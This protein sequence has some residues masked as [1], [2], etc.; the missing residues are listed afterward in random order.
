MA[1]CITDII[2]KQMDHVM[3]LQLT[4]SKKL[5]REKQ[6]AIKWAWL[7]GVSHVIFS[8]DR[9]RCHSNS[10]LQ[11]TPVNCWAEQTPLDASNDSVFLPQPS[12]GRGSIAL[13][14]NSTPI[15]QVTL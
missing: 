15:M 1:S 14:S 8:Y 6:R 7:H 4:L 13:A 9:S 10:W 11:D 5:E 12:R 2:M 3:Q